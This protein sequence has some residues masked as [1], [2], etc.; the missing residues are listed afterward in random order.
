[1]SG[2]VLRKSTAC[3]RDVSASFATGVPM[4]ARLSLPVRLSTLAFPTR[5]ERESAGTSTRLTF[6]AQ[7]ASQKII[8][9]TTG[10]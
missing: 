4:R 5:T 2:G 1:M 3:E 10:C 7:R 9:T 6:A 8:I